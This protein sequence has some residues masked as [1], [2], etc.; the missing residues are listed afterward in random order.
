MAF[1]TVNYSL[2]LKMRIQIFQ[3]P[4]WIISLHF[5]S[6]RILPRCQNLIFIQVSVVNTGQ[7]VDTKVRKNE[8][9][10]LKMACFLYSDNFKNA[11][12]ILFWND[13]AFSFPVFRVCDSC[14]Y[15]NVTQTEKQRL[16]H[17]H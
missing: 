9:K 11:M 3:G 4:S 17:K 7:H 8:I 13:E 2:L 12:L 10:T 14:C 16:R 5:S 15:S 6:F 1:P